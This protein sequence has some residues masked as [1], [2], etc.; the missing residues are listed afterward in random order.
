M[1]KKVDIR[2]IEPCRIEGKPRQPN[3]VL[4]LPEKEAKTLIAMG[5]VKKDDGIEVKVPQRR[6]RNVEKA[7]APAA[8]NTALL[9]RFDELEKEVKKANA[10]AVAANKRADK[11]EKD[12]ADAKKAK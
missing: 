3:A 6:T 2:V 10:A 5:R 11:L 7:V 12:L 4:T 9:N 8:D 1:S